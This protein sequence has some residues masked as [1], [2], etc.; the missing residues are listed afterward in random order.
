MVSTIS[1]PIEI[2]GK[3]AGV[4]GID[5]DYSQIQESLKSIRIISDRTVIMLI[6][7]DGFIIYSTTPEYVGRQLGDVIHGQENADETLRSI[8][9]GRDYFRYGH[10]TALNSQVLKTYTPVQLPPTK[11]TL[12]VKVA[13]RK[14]VV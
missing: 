6:D 4:V 14:S 12:S 7:D 1:V 5:L 2:E 3:T 9:E 8:K 11:Q 13:D 10:S